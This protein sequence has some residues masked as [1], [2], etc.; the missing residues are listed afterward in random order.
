MQRH[1]G[2]V[3]HVQVGDGSLYGWFDDPGSE[4]SSHWWVAKDGRVEQYVD[5]DTESWAQAA[6][7][8]TYN[9]VETEGLPDQ[10]LTADQ[11]NSLAKLYRWGHDTYG[12]RLALSDTVGQLGFAWHGMG[13]VDWGNHPDCPGDL[14]LSARTEILRIAAGAV[15]TPGPPTPKPPEPAPEPAPS[16][17]AFPGRLI[18]QTNP[19]M[20]GD[21]IR[22]WQTQME[23]RGWTI[24]A[25][26][27]YGPES[28]GVCQRF[29]QEKGLVADSIVGP[30]TWDAA[31]D[32]P[33][34]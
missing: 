22:M 13:G 19:M 1:D 29:Q 23:R 28:A 17:P 25:D 21:D 18:H 2:L 8:G 5:A 10:A 24:A 3:L 16:H 4:V 12:W 7:N 34:T 9:S 32:L 11:I 30:I 27:W 26:G 6:G 33:V 14:R 15:I 20:Q 31:W